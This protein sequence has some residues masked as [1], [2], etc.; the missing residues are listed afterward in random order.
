MKWLALQGTKR[1]KQS[2][3]I[4]MGN[5]QSMIFT[6]E[7]ELFEKVQNWKNSRKQVNNLRNQDKMERG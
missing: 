3:E 1:I 4:H 2:A 5:Y 7:E 6:C